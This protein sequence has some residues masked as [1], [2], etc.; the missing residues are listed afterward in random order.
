MASK[1]YFVKARAVSWFVLVLDG[2]SIKGHKVGPI[3]MRGVNYHDRAQNIAGLMRVHGCSFTKAK[4]IER[5]T[6][7][8]GL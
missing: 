4:R 3:K 7:G 8:G 5:D 2:K 6:R 1:S